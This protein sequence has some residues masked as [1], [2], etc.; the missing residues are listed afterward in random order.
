MSVE[1]ALCHPYVA[2]YHDAEDEPAAPSIDPEYFQFEGKSHPLWSISQLIAIYN[3]AHK[4]QLSKDQL[5]D[6]LY[7]EVMSFKPVINTPPK[8]IAP[9]A[10]PWFVL[11]NM[12]GIWSIISTSLLIYHC[13]F[14]LFLSCCSYIHC[15]PCFQ[16]PLAPMRVHVNT[17][18]SLI[19]SSIT[20]LKES[21]ILLIEFS[22]IAV[23]TLSMCSHSHKLQLHVGWIILGW[24]LCHLNMHMV[25]HS[26]CGRKFGNPLNN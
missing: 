6:L 24:H 14:K 9:G 23:H 10:L 4:E 12:V 15:I 5:R 21:A 26:R 3:I 7:E 20:P 17:L 2:A 8:S 13:I 19:C 25:S 16:V 11:W 22:W 18:S 1:E